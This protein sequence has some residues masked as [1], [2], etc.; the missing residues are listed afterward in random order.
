MSSGEDN[1]P[2]ENAC[3]EIP[4]YADLAV[5]MISH[6]RAHVA[7]KRVQSCAEETGGIIATL[8]EL[9][10]WRMESGDAILHEGW[11]LLDSDEYHLHTPSAEQIVLVVHGGGLFSNPNLVQRLEHA[12][13]DKGVEIDKANSFYLQVGINNALSSFPI[14][15]YDDFLWQ[16]NLPRRYGVSIGLEKIHCLA[17]GFLPLGRFEDHQVFIAR[18]GGKNRA[19]NYLDYLAQ[20]GHENIQFEFFEYETSSPLGYIIQSVGD[21]N[22]TPFFGDLATMAEPQYLV[23]CKKQFGEHRGGYRDFAQRK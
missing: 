8:P 13:W 12:S 5:S 22:I 3:Y 19:H 18:C 10:A 23:A 2:T 9:L 14:F 17:N 4:R 7:R 21:A 16:E 6:R 15:S 1:V 11:C 20:R